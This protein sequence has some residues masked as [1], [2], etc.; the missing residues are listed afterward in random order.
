[1]NP[2]TLHQAI[3]AAPFRPFELVLAD[4]S[5][6][7]VPHPEWIAFAGGRVA[8]VTDPDDRAHYVDVMLVTKLELAPPAPAGSIAPNPNGGE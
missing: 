5:R 7:A 3:H 1:M 8:L 2:T 4:G 6:V